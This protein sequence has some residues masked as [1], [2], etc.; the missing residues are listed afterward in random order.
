VSTSIPYDP[1][2]TATPMAPI[3]ASTVILVRDAEPGIEVLMLKRTGGG[4][5]GGFWVFP[6]GRVDAED[7]DELAAAVRE[8]KEESG[9]DLDEAS[10]V[11]F[12]H[13]MPPPVEIKRFATWFFIARAPHLHDVEI[14]QGEIVD[15]EWVR[16]AEMLERRE[17]GEI[18]LAP[19][20][21][22]SLSIIGAHSNVDSVLEEARNTEP[23]LYRTLLHRV[24]DE[25]NG[26]RAFTMWDG[27][28]AYHDPS[29]VD[30]PGPRHR[31]EITASPWVY[32]REL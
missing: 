11:R 29:L 18:E 12:S 4:A 32:V 20:T 24:D 2:P 10:F 22:V 7:A 3:P 23:F 27:D 31:V 13:W 28:V 15:H 9:I 19:P 30:A 16:P 21:F 26:K 1:A 17:R 6:G 5:F 14:D 8:A 25:V